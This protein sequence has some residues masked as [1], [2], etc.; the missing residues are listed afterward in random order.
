MTQN[1]SEIFDF[2]SLKRENGVYYLSD[3]NDE[4]ERLYLETRNSESRV[5]ID[6][7]VKL[8][9]LTDFNYKLHAE[10]NLRKQTSDRFL[11]YLNKKTF[12]TILDI[13]CGN[14]WFTNLLAQSNLDSKVI[15][16][17]INKVELEQASI[18]FN[19]D[20][21]QFLYFDI[22]DD[23]SLFDSKFDLI[24]L[25]AS[26]QYFPDFENL[27]G[28]IKQFLTPKGEIHILDSPFYKKQEIAQAKERTKQYYKSLGSE[29]LSDF[30][31]HH[32]YSELNDFEIFYRPLKGLKRRILNKKESPFY[33]FKFSNSNQVTSVK[34]GFSKIA[35]EYEELEESSSLIQYK[36]KIIRGHLLNRL[37]KGSNLLEINC[38]SGLDALYFAKRGYKVLAT[39]VANGMLQEVKL[40]IGR[41]KLEGKLSCQKVSFDELSKFEEKQFS[42]IFSNFGGLNCIDGSE[43]NQVIKDFA[44][45]IKP[46]GVIT[47]VIMPKNTPY[48]WLRIL[49]GNK[50]AFRRLN[51]DGVIAN[52]KGEKIMT[53]YHS[54]GEVKR[55]L[56]QDFENIQIENIFTFGPSGSSYHY[57][58]K[59]PFLFKVL[60]TIDKFLN[61]IGVLKGVGDYYIISASK[62]I[63]NNV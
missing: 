27:Q 13:G 58:K 7:E 33:W 53:Y 40:K 18:I 45:I 43:I 49:K 57:P 1:N 38:G 37:D 6:E 36:R 19:S 24:T 46:R 15:G 29:E 22:F 32:S 23:L 62:K 39:D 2:D 47:L 34:K 25:N 51:T 56:K 16:I 9:P 60:I 44:K 54:A 5:L 4:F 63:S 48:E 35:E 17:D 3:V 61:K 8:L 31:H 10:W 26:A 11:Y 41:N 30:Y 52:V 50:S 14:G 21:L 12:K 42:G 59:Y 28:R 20:N 55:M